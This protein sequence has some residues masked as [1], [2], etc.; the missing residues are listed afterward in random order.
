MLNAQDKENVI[1]ASQTA[2]LLAQD[3]QS[4]VKSDDPLLSDLALEL[5]EPVVRIEQRLKR[6]ASLTGKD[7]E[8]S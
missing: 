6:V 4:I 5:L 2:N 7:A 1:K 3:L 8:A